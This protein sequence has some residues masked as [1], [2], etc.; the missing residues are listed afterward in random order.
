MYL[1]ALESLLLIMHPD[2]VP[3]PRLPLESTSGEAP[4]PREVADT[5]DN[6]DRRRDLFAFVPPHTLAPLT[7][8]KHGEMRK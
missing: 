7:P 1:P 8:E 2:H 6:H 5:P 3:D 4:T